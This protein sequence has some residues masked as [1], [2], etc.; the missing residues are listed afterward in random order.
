[1][2]WRDFS[3]RLA[4]NHLQVPMADTPDELDAQFARVLAA[5]KSD[6]V[7]GPDD[8]LQ[9]SQHGA[10]V[11]ATSD[12]PGWVGGLESSDTVIETYV[13]SEAGITATSDNQPFV[14]AW[15]PLVSWIDNQVRAALHRFDLVLTGD[16]YVTASL[17]ETAS[18]EGLAH[19][20]DDT[21]APDAPVG[22]V[23]IIGQ[24]V[25][26]RVATAPV[27]HAPLRPMSQIIFD[28]E[29]LAD[30]G[31]DRIDHV[32]SDPDQLVIF[33]QFGQL[34][35]GPAAEH[36]AHLG[37]SRQLLVYRANAQPA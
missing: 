15:M 21:F 26:P 1:M 23:A 28:D 27:A 5:R 2:N 20:D 13:A 18:L 19:M 3:C 7:S 4:T 8:E 25:G 14:D 17:T 30:F 9:V 37:S 32:A 16:A 12:F 11:I 24:W 10:A 6:Y 34:H 31:A 36:T 33:P 29:T 22:V 35:A